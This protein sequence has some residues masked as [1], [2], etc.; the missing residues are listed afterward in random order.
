[1]ERVDV[2]TLLSANCRLITSGSESTIIELEDG[3]ILKLF[4]RFKLQNQ[5]GYEGYESFIFIKKLR[6][7]FHQSLMN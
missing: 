3:S 5:L 1:M 4:D 2:E 6:F 7:L